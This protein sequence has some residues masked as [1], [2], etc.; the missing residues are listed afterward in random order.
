AVVAA[1]GEGAFA[2]V[3]GLADVSEAAGVRP[4]A[5]AM[6]IESVTRLRARICSEIGA[7]REGDAANATPTT[8]AS[9]SV[10]NPPRPS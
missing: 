3:L 10:L 8:A 6:A 4:I 9:A 5:L 7:L 2:G 1:I